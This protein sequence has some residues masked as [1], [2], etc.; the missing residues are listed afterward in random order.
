[1]FSAV[2]IETSLQ[3]VQ[4][5]S[6]EKDEMKGVLSQAKESAYCLESAFTSFTKARSHKASCPY[7]YGPSFRIDCRGLCHEVYT[8]KIPCT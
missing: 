6:D 3:N 8:M 5:L 1:M 2:E 7:E 4:I